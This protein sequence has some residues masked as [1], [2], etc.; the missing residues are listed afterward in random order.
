VQAYEVQPEDF[1]VERAQPDSIRGGD[2]E[3]NAAILLDILQGRSGPTRD[4][5]VMNAGAALY[6]AG[7]VDSFRDGA[8]MAAEAL[9]SRAAHTTLERLR[10][11]SQGARQD[12]GSAA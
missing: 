11:S 7:R 12:V 6:A 8:R 2:P 10:A 1:G 3:T 9:D 5:A 4:A